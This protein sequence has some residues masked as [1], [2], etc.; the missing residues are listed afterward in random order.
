MKAGELI[1]SI[2][3]ALLIPA[4]KRAPVIGPLTKSAFNR[5]AFLR[6]FDEFDESAVP[7]NDVELAGNGE[8]ARDISARGEDLVKDFEGLFLRAYD[9]GGGV[10]TIG[11]GHTGLQHNDGTVY[12]GRVIT[13]EKAE[14]LFRYD[15]EQFEASVSALVRVP[16]NDDEYAALVSFDFNTGALKGS[17]LLK[18]LNAGDNRADIA[19]EEFPKWNHDNGRVV[20]GLTRRRLSERNLF[21]GKTPFIVE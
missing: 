7:A 4:E 21:L 20:A 12:P 14:Q 15:M 18:R 8:N 2:Q 17:T 5:L 10:W 16:L 6:P 1:L 3:A 13:A 9:D 11:W 19:N